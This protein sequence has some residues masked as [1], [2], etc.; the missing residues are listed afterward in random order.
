M[1]NTRWKLIEDWQ[2]RKFAFGYLSSNTLTTF[3]TK[4]KMSRY[5]LRIQNSPRRVKAQRHWR[6]KYPP[7]SLLLRY[8][9]VASQRHRILCQGHPLRYF[10]LVYR[11]GNLET[12]NNV[13]DAC[14]SHEY[15]ASINLG[16]QSRRPFRQA[17]F[18]A[19]I[20]EPVTWDIRFW[21]GIGKVK[22][23]QE[24]RYEHF[25]VPI[26]F[27]RRSFSTFTCSTKNAIPSTGS[28]H[29]GPWKVASWNPVSIW[30]SKSR[31]I[32][33]ISKASSSDVNRCWRRLSLHRN[34][35]KLEKQENSGNLRGVWL[36]T[37]CINQ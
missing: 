24:V 27:A 26:S 25:N 30:L 4:K 21:A 16:D 34:Y 28:A 7:S 31:T 17:S 19:D 3:M 11:V 29:K 23:N 9:R 32:F 14:I 15:M 8:G 37:P 6:K 5:H 1:I 36:W 22:G 18:T 13:P 35:E 33:S 20:S 12:T 2:P 10:Y